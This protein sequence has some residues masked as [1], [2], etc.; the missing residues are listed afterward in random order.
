MVRAMHPD[1]EKLVE[2]GRI[3]AAVGERLSQLA[4]GSFCLHKSWGSGKV[5]SWD[6]LAGKVTIDFEKE[7]GRVMGL[8]LALEKTETIASDDFRAEK[9]DKSKELKKLAKEKPQEVV[10]Q[11]LLSHGGSM[12]PDQ[13][14]RLLCGSVVPEEDYKKWWDKAKKALR[15]TRKVVVPS[16]RNE[17]LVLRDTDLTP[18]EILLQ[19]FEE[20]RDLRVKAS[21]LEELRKDAKVLKDDEPARKRILDGTEE[22]ARKGMKLHLGAVLDL[23]AGRDELFEGLKGVELPDSALR[24]LDVL[25][26]GS[27]LQL[28]TELAGLSAVRQR[29]IFDSFPEAY[30]DVWVTNIL[31]VFDRVGT[32][33]VAEIAKLFAD[34][35]ESETLLAHIR[36]ALSRHALGPDALAWICRERKK[37]SKDAFGH[38]VGSALLSVIE[39]DTTDEGPRRSLRLQNLLMEDRTLIPDLLD[40]VDTNEVRNF[41]RKLLSSPAF[42]ELDRKSLMA[43]VIKS[44]PETQELVT[45]ETN[46]QKESLVV[47]WESLEKRKLEYEDLV[48]NRIPQNVKDIAVARSYGDLRENFEYKASKQQ[49]VVLNKFRIDMEKELTIAQGTDFSGADVSGVNIGTVVVLVTADGSEET[50]TVLGAWDSV[51]EEKIVSYLSDIGQALIGEKPGA[52]VEIKDLETEKMQVVTIKSIS[53]WKK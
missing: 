8:K 49:Q 29:R 52:T 18:L 10:I 27:P 11:V 23:L 14:D 37:M 1:V 2:S 40:G 5:A 22:S 17:P 31:K 7:P 9:I 16:K 48:N 25:A 45:G 26:A 33:G 4:P 41:A 43:R 21:V 50:Y 53:A 20:A 51:P 39:Q 30:G 32:R 15:E 3:P 38:E 6:L 35:D 13:I 34:R 46:E 47:S 19:D 36:K 28:S 24:I 42:P 12:K 44:H